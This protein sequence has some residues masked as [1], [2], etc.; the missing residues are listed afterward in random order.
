MNRHSRS[1]HLLLHRSLRSH[2]HGH[3]V[4]RYGITHRSATR[5]AWYGDSTGGHI[6]FDS[7]GICRYRAIHR[8]CIGHALLHGYAP[9]GGGHISSSWNPVGNRVGH[10]LRVSR[11][12]GTWILVRIPS[13]SDGLLIGELLP[14]TLSSESSLLHDHLSPVLFLLLEEF[15]LSLVLQVAQVHRICGWNLGLICLVDLANR[16]NMRSIL[17]LLQH[18]LTLLGQLAHRVQKSKMPSCP[19]SIDPNRL[20]S[21]PSD[22]S[23]RLRIALLGCLLLLCGLLRKYR[24]LSSFQS[25]IIRTEILGLGHLS[26]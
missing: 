17:L 6:R 18:C 7:H 3:R 11:W 13:S 8:P 25:L 21:F 14:S 26:R 12:H 2:F 9:C 20:C 23:L 16:C 5:H 10:W 19:P 1:R 24:T 4:R 22:H 15:L